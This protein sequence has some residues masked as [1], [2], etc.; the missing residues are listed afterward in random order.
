MATCLNEEPAPARI[1]VHPFL[2]IYGRELE[3]VGKSLQLTGDHVFSL[4]CIAI[5]R[6]RGH[7]RCV[8]LFVI[9]VG[10]CLE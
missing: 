2:H 6:Y 1:V 5:C 10:Q 4:S 9:S 3:I 8:F 7:R